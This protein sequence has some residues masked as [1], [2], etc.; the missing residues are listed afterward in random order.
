[1]VLMSAVALAAGLALR[2]AVE[3]N[4]RIEA[5]G[6]SRQVF[7]VLPNIL[8]KQLAL[9]RTNLSAPQSSGQAGTRVATQQN[10]DRGLGISRAD[11]KLLF[12]GSENELSFMTSFSRQGSLYQGLSWVHYR[13]DAASNTLL[14]YQQIMTRAEDVNG[15]RSGLNRK[16]T[17]QTEPDLVGR[18]ENVTTFRLSYAEE[19]D[20]EWIDTSAWMSFWECDPGL[21]AVEA[22]VP[23]QVS[24][25]LEVGVDKGR[26]SGLWI[27]PV[28]WE[29]GTQ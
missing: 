21:S 6:D 26:Q 12:C 1:M 15:E 16:R 13:Y 9:V 29:P 28:H 8:E 22:G 3:A 14:V 17:L 19:V 23:A 27:L 24:L 20:T 25:F 18:I 7:S 5:E 11:N 10:V 4:E 2:L